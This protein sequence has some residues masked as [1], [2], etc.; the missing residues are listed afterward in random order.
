[1]NDVKVGHMLVSQ[2]QI[3]EE[4]LYETLAIQNVL[5]FIDMQSDLPDLTPQAD[6]D[7]HQCLRL[8]CVLRRRE[9]EATILATS[10]L[11]QFKNSKA[12][13]PAHLHP[14]KMAIATRSH[15]TETTRVGASTIMAMKA[16][17]RVPEDL[18]CRSL[19]AEIKTCLVW[20]YPC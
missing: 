8:Q 16:E 4:S 17:T 2:G 20:H 9:G 18:S 14:V 10:S 5:P 1:M 6:M 13:L 11:E 3:S 19:P 12:T 7:P 15:I